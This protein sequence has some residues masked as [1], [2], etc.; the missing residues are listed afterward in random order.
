MI[1]DVELRPLLTQ[2][3]ERDRAQIAEKN[4]FP[5]ETTRSRLGIS[6]G[7]PPCNYSVAYPTF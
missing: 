6:G 7:P 3:C 5:S 4:S 2:R 1:G